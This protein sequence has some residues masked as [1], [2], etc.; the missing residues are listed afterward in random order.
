M[1]ARS[2]SVRLDLRK[3]LRRYLCTDDNSALRTI[4]D[5][6]KQWPRDTRPVLYEA[7]SQVL[8]GYP[9]CKVDR[10]L[11]LAKSIDVQLDV[12]DRAVMAFCFGNT[13]EAIKL[14]DEAPTKGRH[15]QR[16]LLWR[17]FFQNK[18]ALD[19]AVHASSEPVRVF[20]FWDKTPPPDVEAAMDEWRD[21][22]GSSYYARFDD[23]SARE[24]LADTAIPGLVAAYDAARH[25]AMKADIFRLV[26]LLRS[27]GLYVD[28]DTR[29]A[30]DARNVLR[31]AS[32]SLHL[33]FYAHQPHG[34]LQNA[35]MLVEAGHPILTLAIE[36]CINNVL[37]G[38][39]EK[40]SVA[41]GPVVI[42][43]AFLTLLEKGAV[44]ATM[45]AFTECNTRLAR[46][47][48]ASYKGDDRSWHLASRRDT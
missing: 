14:I 34:L 12:V 25:P 8:A 22:A 13:E 20:Q 15:R 43:N 41:T 46:N 40:V 47:F 27:G 30:P 7:F 29:P 18:S 23:A 28:A 26:Y 1:Q 48:A 3:A 4:I 31:T 5:L 44:P 2:P 24:V 32:R 6:S 10:L 38:E 11:V 9:Q 17:A 42:T 35:V 16:F 33:A 39:G 21:L 19:S 37:N 36:A 45:M